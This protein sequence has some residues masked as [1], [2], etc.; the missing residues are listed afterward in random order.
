MFGDARIE[1]ECDRCGTQE[2][3]TLTALVRNTWDDRELAKQMEDSG[4]VSEDGKHFCSEVCREDDTEP[5]D[6]D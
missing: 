2:D 5:E 6:E 1:I 3:F 4:W